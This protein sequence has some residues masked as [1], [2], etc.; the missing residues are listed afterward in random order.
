MHKIF[1]SLVFLYGVGVSTLVGYETMRDMTLLEKSVESGY[2]HA[3]MRHRMNVAAEGNWF[4]MGNMIA[5]AGI[6]GL[7]TKNDKKNN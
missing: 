3:E 4:L 2:H 1:F 7:C 5:I 6:F